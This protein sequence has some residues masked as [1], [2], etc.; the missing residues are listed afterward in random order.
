M[1]HFEGDRDFSLPP[2]ALFN[3][4][5]DAS[6]LVTCVPQSTVKGTPTRDEAACS[7]TTGFTF[8]RGTLDAVIKIVE[9][10]EPTLV[11]V[12][13]QSK[14]IGISSDIVASLT[15]AAAES[16]SRVHWIADVERLGGLL[17]AVPAGLIR[18]AAQKT[19]D[20][21]LTGIQKKLEA[22]A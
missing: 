15:I 19:I 7:V 4:L 13:L 1:L 10:Q 14:G 2:E 21:I 22:A 16:G 5:R 18:G 20:D 3:K 8:V 9:A 17:K 6:F 12:L 11:K